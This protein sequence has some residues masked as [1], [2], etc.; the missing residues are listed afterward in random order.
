M[1][2]GTAR[3]AVDDAHDDPVGPV[4]R[5]AGEECEP[6]LE[7]LLV[8]AGAE[9]PEALAGGRRDEGGNG[10]P[11]EPVMAAGD[12]ALAARRPDPSQ[13]RLQP[14]V[15]RDRRGARR[16]RRPRPPRRGGAPPPRRRPRQAFLERLPP[17][18]RRRL[19]A[20]RPRAPDRP[21][22]R[23]KG[24]PAGQLGDACDPEYRATIRFT[25]RSGCRAGM[26]SS[27]STQLNSDP[28]LLSVPRIACLPAAAR[29]RTR[30]PQSVSGAGFFGSLRAACPRR[31]RPA[32]ESA[33]ARLTSRGR[34]AL[35][36]TAGADR[37]RR[38]RI[39]AHPSP[40]AGAAGPGCAPRTR[41]SA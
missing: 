12:R 6:V 36:A 20:P 38:P 1:P 37:L 13:D 40:F 32:S 29:R 17:L 10:E 23:A 19:R 41:S 3:G 28:L 35:G 25:C 27:M 11:P 39:A 21:A 14:D 15:A 33:R 16:W 5:L 8:D 18:G 9:I 4:A 22:D 7:A 31:F 24:L 30:I 2:S 34:H 26:R